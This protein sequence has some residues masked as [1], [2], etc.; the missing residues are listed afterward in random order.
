MEEEWV[1]I[2]DHRQDKDRP[3]QLPELVEKFFTTGTGGD[4][5][6]TWDF[7]LLNIGC[8]HLIDADFSP[9]LDEQTYALSHM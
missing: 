2:S 8:N 1:D 5:S 4:S 6:T 9:V 7:C 3:A